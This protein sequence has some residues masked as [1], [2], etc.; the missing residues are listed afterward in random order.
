MGNVNQNFTVPPRPKNEN[1]SF[2]RKRFVYPF[3]LEFMELPDNTLV[4]NDEILVSLSNFVKREK[5]I[6]NNHLILREDN[7][8][9]NLIG[10][11]NIFYQNI[12]EIK[13]FRENISDNTIFPT[14]LRYTDLAKYLKYCSSTLHDVKL[15]LDKTL[16]K[17]KSFIEYLAYK[18]IKIFDSITKDDKVL[19]TNNIFIKVFSNPFLWRELL[20][21][22]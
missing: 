18:Q 10:T 1:S 8:E 4:G 7:R 5:T 13:K 19:N 9:F 3:V 14:F 11:L 6:N 22:L 17:K 21:Y 20:L 2:F 12:Y 16:F 15:F